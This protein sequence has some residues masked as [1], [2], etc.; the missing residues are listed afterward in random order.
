MRWRPILAAAAAL[1]GCG[2]VPAPEDVPRYDARDA[3]VEERFD[4]AVTDVPGRFDVIPSIDVIA[5]GDAA[6]AADAGPA[7]DAAACQAVSEDYAS[8]VRDAQSCR[9]DGE[10]DAPVCETLCC[11][12][13]VYVSTTASA[14]ARLQ[15]LR[16]RWAALG[17]A[18]MGRCAGGGGCG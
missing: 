14:F 1:A 9:V 2:D 6:S 12:C 16:E 13:Q 5:L 11:A 7:D 4:A 3:V 17:C 15:L 8:A 10:C 18:T